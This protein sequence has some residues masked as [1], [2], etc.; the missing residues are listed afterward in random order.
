MDVDAPTTAA[1]GVH[2]D[3]LDVLIGME[4]AVTVGYPFLLAVRASE[5]HRT[6]LYF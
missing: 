1:A 6:R 2:E 3:L 5:G 4:D